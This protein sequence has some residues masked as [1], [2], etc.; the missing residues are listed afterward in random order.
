MRLRVRALAAFVR[1]RRWLST[2]T[3]AT[4][5]A[6]KFDLMGRNGKVK[7]A[8]RRASLE[9]TQMVRRMALGAMVGTGLRAREQHITSIHYR[10]LGSVAYRGL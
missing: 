9:L 2:L 8:A 5:I 1:W 10:I 4:T 7:L 6:H 3:S